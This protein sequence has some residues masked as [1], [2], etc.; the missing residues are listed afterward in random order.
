MPGALGGGC[1]GRDSRGRATGRYQHCYLPADQI[2]RQ[3]RQATIVAARPA[4]V[5]DGILP[6][7]GRTPIT[8]TSI[9]VSSHPT[10]IRPH[11]REEPMAPY[12][13]KVGDIVALNPAVSRNVSGG[14]LES[15]QTAPRHEGAWINE[16]HERVAAESELSKA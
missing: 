11:R 3:C 2:G 15:H 4:E 13:F 16:P 6:F 7:D 9:E 8:I 5:D 14:V 1:F 10:V 12:K